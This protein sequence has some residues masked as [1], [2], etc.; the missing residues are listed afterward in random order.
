MSAAFFYTG[1]KITCFGDI[2]L[3]LFFM[4]SD[5]LKKGGGICVRKFV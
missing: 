2:F 1:D 4:Q 5:I 3:L